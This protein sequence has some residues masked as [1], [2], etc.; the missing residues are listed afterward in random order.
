MKRLMLAG[1]TLAIVLPAVANAS[2]TRPGC[3]KRYTV[4]MG[5]RA[6][7]A[8]YDGTR[9]V[10]LHDLRLLGYIERCQR[11]PANQARVRT[12]DR[13][14]DVL[15]RYRV[16]PPMTTVVA[17]WY[18][19]E[20]STACGFHATYGVANKTLPCGY[21]VMMAHDGNTVNATVDDRGPFVPGR[22]YDL[23]QATKAALA[24][25]DLCDVEVSATG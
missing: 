13:H 12:F 8:V 23:D 14:M 25:P 15:H 7:H 24:C 22:D 9:H 18:Y 2:A 10:T 1:A 6:A 5:H 20:G 11:H 17:S 21:H 4:A 16:A 19:D 3:D